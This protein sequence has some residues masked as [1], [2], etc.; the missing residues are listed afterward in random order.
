M[1]TLLS[2]SD[3]RC[4]AW[5]KIVHHIRRGEQSCAENQCGESS[6][7]EHL[8]NILS[9]QCR[10]RLNW[11]MGAD[12]V[13]D[14]VH[15]VVVTVLKAIHEGRLHD[16]ERLLGYT[17]TL[18]QRYAFRHIRGSISA[19]KRYVPLGDDE[20]ATPGEP[21]PEL[22]ILATEQTEALRRVLQCLR[23]RDREIL[24]RYYYFEQDPVHICGQMRL[25]PTQFRLFKSRALARCSLMAARQ[26]R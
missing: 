4:T 26:S 7:A 16:P 15:D 11:S 20:I 17:R 13:E 18:A 25:T 21:S 19:R 22:A 12:Q 5:E 8:C 14:G 6:C 23:E 10:A 9:G 24:I 1:S 2:I 3:N